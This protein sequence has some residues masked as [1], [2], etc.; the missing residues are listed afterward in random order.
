MPLDLIGLLKL[1]DCDLAV[2]PVY[3]DRDLDLQY[4][5]L[6][7]LSVLGFLL[8]GCVFGRFSSAALILAFGA[9]LLVLAA[10]ALFS[11]VS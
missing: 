10:L 2:F 4:I 11:F 9:F 6:F 1:R 5:F 3:L 8:L 7:Q